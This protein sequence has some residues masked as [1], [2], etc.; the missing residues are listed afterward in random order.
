MS[1]YVPR[2]QPVSAR[3]LARAVIRLDLRKHPAKVEAITR[4]LVRREAMERKAA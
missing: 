2:I 4:E 1:E 3:T